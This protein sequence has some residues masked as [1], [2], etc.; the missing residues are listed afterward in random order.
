MPYYDLTC[1]PASP[2]QRRRGERKFLNIGTNA[3]TPGFVLAAENMGWEISQ[4][5]NM[6]LD[7]QFG[8]H[9]DVGNDGNAVYCS[10][11]V[12]VEPSDD[13]A[14]P[15][16]IPVDV[17]TNRDS[18]KVAKNNI[19][20]WLS[21]FEK[22]A[23]NQDQNVYLAPDE[24]VTKA[25][26]E[27]VFEAICNV[28]EH[29]GENSTCHLLA[30]AGVRA[31]ASEFVHDMISIAVSDTGTGIPEKM[32]GCGLPEHIKSKFFK[33][34]N[35]DRHK[36]L[37]G[38]ILKEQ[39]AT[40]TEVE[41][42]ATLS[43]PAK[44]ALSLLPGVTVEARGRGNHGKGL[45]RMRMISK[46]FCVFTRSRK[47]EAISLRTH[48]NYDRVSDRNEFREHFKDETPEPRLPRYDEF[49]SR[50][51]KIPKKGLAR[52]PRPFLSSDFKYVPCLPKNVVNDWEELSPESFCGTVVE[53][54]VGLRCDGTS[55][56]LCAH[57]QLEKADGELNAS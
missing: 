23:T 27:G 13:E 19:C 41:T 49:E 48:V 35:V 8:E 38:S 6:V 45:T 16:H 22:S 4:T 53:M 40:T 9:L 26:A 29:S 10:E 18:D 30:F 57:C 17:T 1:I 51:I 52:N 32:E 11:K 21:E 54:V 56:C 20:I 36:N 31:D 7:F 46:S 24:N 34:L 15:L 12:N 42:D 39:D 55:A 44:V 33:D 2:F 37:F 5:G 25:I 3:F 47:S 50:E 28:L 43:D 14:G